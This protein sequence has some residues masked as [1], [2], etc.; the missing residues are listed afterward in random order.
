MSTTTDR[1]VALEGAD[2]VV[3][4]I[5]TGAFESMRHDLEIPERHGIKQ[6]VGDTVGPGGI[7]RSTLLNITAVLSGVVAAFGLLRAFLLLTQS[8]GFPF[9]IAGFLVTIGLTL[10]A[11]TVAYWAARESFLKDQLRGRHG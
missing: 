9:R 4:C 5:S 8:G 1:R 2:Y 11:A 7:S 3:V 10:A 6:S